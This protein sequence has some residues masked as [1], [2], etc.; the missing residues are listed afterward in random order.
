MPRAYDDLKMTG[1][2]FKH[3]IWCCHLVLEGL[4]CKFEEMLD[5]YHSLFL[6]T[7]DFNTDSF[8]HLHKCSWNRMLVLYLKGCE[9]GMVAVQ[10]SWS[11]QQFDG[12]HLFLSEYWHPVW[13]SQLIFHSLNSYTPIFGRKKK[14][15]ADYQRDHMCIARSC[16]KVLVLLFTSLI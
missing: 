8:T 14:T 16:L 12:S 1:K 3:F 6:T 11:Q 13:F 10:N 9:V 15:F 7:S 4:Q 5:V 2:H